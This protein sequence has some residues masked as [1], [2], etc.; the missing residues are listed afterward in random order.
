MRISPPVSSGVTY[1]D[2]KIVKTTSFDPHRNLQQ[3]VPEPPQRDESS[4]MAVKSHIRPNLQVCCIMKAP[5]T[6]F[7]II[8]SNKSFYTL[9]KDLAKADNFGLLFF[10]LSS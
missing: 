6:T 10:S 1:S 5:R 7:A 9:C 4:A 3:N 8:F 2:A